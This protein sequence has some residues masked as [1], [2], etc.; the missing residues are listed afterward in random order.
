MLISLAQGVRKATEIVAE[1]TKSRSTTYDI[2]RAA[3]DYPVV[4]YTSNGVSVT[5]FP[6]GDIYSIATDTPTKFYTDPT[7]THPF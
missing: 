3:W 4:P 7:A 6:M 2:L 1:I 5:W